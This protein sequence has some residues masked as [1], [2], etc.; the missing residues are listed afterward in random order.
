MRGLGEGGDGQD[1]TYK[2]NNRSDACP[3]GFSQED[4]VAA[5]LAKGYD[6]YRTL[7]N[8]SMLDYGGKNESDPETGVQ[9]PEKVVLYGS[10]QPYVGAVRYDSNSEITRMYYTG[11]GNYSLSFVMPYAGDYDFA[12]STWGTLSACVSTAHPFPF[13][14]TGSLGILSIQHNNTVVKVTF[15]YMTNEINVVMKS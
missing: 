4:A 13:S 10:F 12:V 14:G 11:N 9:F 7:A 3:D 15:N 8:P 2:M 1:H 6:A 5:L